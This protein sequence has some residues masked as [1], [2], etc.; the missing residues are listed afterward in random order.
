MSARAAIGGPTATNVP[1]LRKRS[2][3]GKLVAEVGD[4]AVPLT[5]LDKLMYPAAGFT[6]GQV[7]DYY[8]RMAPVLLPHVRGRPLTLKRF[9]DG[10]GGA[11]FYEKNCPAHRPDWVT[12]VAIWT[13]RAQEHFHY[14][15]ITEEATI[16][17]LANLA[18]R[19]LL[20]PPATA[21]WDDRPTWMTLD[22]FPGDPARLLEAPWRA[23]MLHGLFDRL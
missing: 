9:P 5:N 7:I 19:E 6:K 13:E 4:R 20:P 18:A 16:I 1:T 12:T 10:V 14:C 22:L 17:W 23:L 2:R 11:Y 3:D 15:A 8:A 21:E